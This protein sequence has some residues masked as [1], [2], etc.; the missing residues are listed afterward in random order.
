MKK[1][2]KTSLLGFAKKVLGANLWSTQRDIL[3]AIESE[4]QVA[5]AACHAS[6][7][8]YVAACAAIGFAALHEDARV[9]VISP[10][11][12]GVRTV[13]WAEIHS[14]IERGKVKLPTIVDNQTELRFG[15]RNLILGLSAADS[16]RL[17]GHHAENILIIIDE[18]AG[19][20][21]SFW[22]SIHGILAGGH[23]R[24][25][26]LGNPTT[27]HGYFYDCFG[28]NRP[29]WKTFSIS[30]FQSPN[31]EGVS[32]ERLLAMSDDELDTNERPYLVTRRWVHERYAEWWN[33]SVENSPI[34]ASRVLGEFPSESS[35]ALI[36]LS[37]LEAARKP[38]ADSRG[39]VTIGIDLA[40]PGRDRSVAI[41]CAGSAILETGIW[42]GDS[43]GAIVAFIRRWGRRVKQVNCDST[44]IGWGIV[45]RLHAERLGVRIH[46]LNAASSAR[47]KD[48]FANDKA[49]RYWYLRERFVKERTVSGL[50][51]D[52]LAE[53]AA[54]NYVVD[55]HGR[56]AIED[57]A[58]VKSALGRSP[59]LAEAL[60]LAIGSPAPERFTFT[61]VPQQFTFYRPGERQAG[62]TPA[63]WGSQAWKDH[64]ED[65]RNDRI[66]A[67]RRYGGRQFMFFPGKIY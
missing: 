56:T 12:L 33:G 60:M 34:W 62:A 53:L 22:P 27:T 1:T 66:R 52:M 6:G 55:A 7:K 29:A 67:A 39:D 26:L 2:T 8:S 63:G 65:Q 59:D 45:Q 40:G 51:D 25:L 5:V 21:E 38:A 23:A 54:I 46:G 49:A 41:A 64:L 20:D 44:G 11:W 47:E 58:S 9:I 28:R 19:I 16:A 13:L 37:A 30:A 50:T 36:P 48:R 57:K 31:L 61:P 14:L 32:L 24:L 4:R 3:K 10:G 18:A 43:Y 15:S 17:Q 35:N 42:T